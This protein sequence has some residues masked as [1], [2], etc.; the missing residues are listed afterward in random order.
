MRRIGLAV[1]L[2]FSV[3]L[4][5]GSQAQQF[6]S[7][8]RIGFL[9]VGLTPESSEAQHFRNGLR[10]A[11]YAEGR[12]VVIEWRSAHGDFDRVPDLLADFL[13]TKVDVIVV[14]ST[15]AAQMAMRST[16]TVPIVMAL[17]LDPVR[18]GLVKSLAYPGGNVTG[19]SMMSTELTSKRLQLA[20]EAIPRLTRLAVLWNPD[21]PVHA[22]VYGDLT[23]MAPAL[24]MQLSS[25]GVRTPDQFD[26]AFLE[27]GRAQPQALYVLDDPV[28]WAH[29]AVL[30]KLASKAHVPTMFEL[31]RWAKEGGLMSYGA[32]TK[33]LFYRAASYVDRILQGAK[34][35][36]LPVEQPRKFELVI[37]IK[38]AQTFGLKIPPTLLLRADEVI[39]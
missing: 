36:H 6:G 12:N 22:K 3:A 19:V 39:Q 5:L 37:N 17:V 10:D 27:I 26:A 16:S 25:A 34:P 4:V 30:L 1:G 15:V 31:S 7:P 2:I 33:D 28:F 35:A 13:R 11:G 29:R 23:E 38:T 8:R 24:S 20:R 18:S 32:D 9:L 14:D 21:H